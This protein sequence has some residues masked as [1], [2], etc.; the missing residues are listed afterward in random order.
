MSDGKKERRGFEVVDV[1][2][3]GDKVGKSIKWPLAR[4]VREIPT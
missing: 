2:F 3:I 4:V 1:V